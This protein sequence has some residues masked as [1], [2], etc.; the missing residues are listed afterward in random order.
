MLPIQTTSKRTQRVPLIGQLRRIGPVSNT[1]LLNKPANPRTPDRSRHRFQTLA[2]KSTDFLPSG[3]PQLIEFLHMDNH[4]V[5][6]ESTHYL[7]RIPSGA[8]PSRCIQSY[9]R[10][11]RWHSSCD[12]MKWQ[13]R[14][15]W[16]KT[17]C[18]LC[19]SAPSLCPRK[20]HIPQHYALSIKSFFSPPPSSYPITTVLT[21]CNATW[22][23]QHDHGSNVP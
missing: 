20:F 4:L 1:K 19:L 2:P 12:G 7:P 21:L 3:L 15:L 23:G 18:I 9:R 13:P 17:A 14:V 6:L 22:V 5:Q 10:L 11:N 16:V 8:I